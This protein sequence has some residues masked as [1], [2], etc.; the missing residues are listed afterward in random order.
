[1]KK[2]YFLLI[3]V[4]LASCASVKPVKVEIKPNGDVIATDVTDSEVGNIDEV[5][6]TEV[7]EDNELFKVSKFVNF[8]KK[9]ISDFYRV[10]KKH[11]E[12]LNSVCFESFMLKRGLR[13]TN[14]KS[15]SEVIKHL[16]TEKPIL[17]FENYWSLKGV[18]GYTYPNSKRIWMNK[19][20][21]RKMSDCS[22]AG[23]IGH[24]RS[25][26][27]NYGHSF[28]YHSKRPYS[29]P[30]SINAAFKSCCK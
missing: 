11:D 5:E 14:G 1:M 18:V 9:E 7:I 28:K 8:T 29:V 15:H 24:E 25:H 6:T 19:R 30:Y 20:L 26:K 3:L 10:T 21:H 16:R 17:E 23:N 2:M 22:R 27:L 12:T 13:K 4:F